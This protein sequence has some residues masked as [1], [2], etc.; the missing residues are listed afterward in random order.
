NTR[1]HQEP[2]GKTD[3]DIARAN[4]DQ[5]L[6]DLILNAMSV[7]RGTCEIHSQHLRKKADADDAEAQYELA[8]LYM[9]G[10]GVPR[11]CGE[12]Y[13]C[14]LRARDSGNAA[15]VSNVTTACNEL[16]ELLASDERS[17][18]ALLSQNS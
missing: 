12:A 18:L 14:Y 10:E 13:Y 8:C 1:E 16:N 3:Y 15:I 17:R 11:D 4:S 2:D 5:Y 9:K 7:A 6:P